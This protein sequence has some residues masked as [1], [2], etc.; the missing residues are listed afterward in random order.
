MKQKPTPTIEDYLGV[1]YTLD[2]D[3][4]KVIGARLAKLLDVSP[5]TV[6]VTLKRMIRDNWIS[7]DKSKHIHLTSSGNKAAQS[8]IRRHMLTE[9]LLSR[10]LDIPWSELHAEADKLE[11]SISKYVEDRLAA[12][13][14]D[15][16]VCP[17][18]NPMPGHESI[19]NDWQ[20]LTSFTKGDTCIIKRIHEW[21]EDDPEAMNYLEENLV[22]PG[23]IAS[24]QE[25][26]PF[27][28][29]IQIKIIEKSVTIGFDVADRIFAEGI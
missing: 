10:V 13:F 21:V 24:I 3:G 16:S 22:L 9:W 27:N 14:E 28:K 7:I 18:G 17:H 29:T 8:V 6:T 26:L 5:P 2:R 25:V 15:P 20:T 19:S 4:E 11:H 1:I 12:T 23:N